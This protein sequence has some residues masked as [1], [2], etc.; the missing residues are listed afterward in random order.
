MKN[1]S[2]FSAQAVPS[3]KSLGVGRLE[4]IGELSNRAG[5]GAVD[6]NAL[7]ATSQSY[8]H[9]HDFD[10]AV[11]EGYGANQSYEMDHNGVMDDEVDL[12]AYDSDLDMITDDGELDEEVSFPITEC[13]IIDSQTRIYVVHIPL[14]WDR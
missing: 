4:Q 8:D 7:V 3:P 5:A 2:P 14:F 13:K 1:K 12:D 10:D 9:D 11:T 6:S